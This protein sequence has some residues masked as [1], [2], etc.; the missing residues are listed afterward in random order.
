MCVYCLHDRG[1]FYVMLIFESL[2]MGDCI[3]FKD[4]NLHFSLICG[5]LW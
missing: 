1:H 5:H 3:T 4:E 2:K